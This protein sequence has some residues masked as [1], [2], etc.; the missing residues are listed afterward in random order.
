MFLCILQ[1]LIKQLFK[2]GQSCVHKNTHNLTAFVSS[3]PRPRRHTCAAVR[4]PAIGETTHI[5]TR[6]AAAAGKQGHQNTKQDSA[7]EM[8]CRF[9]DGRPTGH[10]AV[11]YSEGGGGGRRDA[12]VTQSVEGFYEPSEVR[13]FSWKAVL[14]KNKSPSNP[15]QF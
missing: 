3:A 8:R 11:I 14:K 5:W 4:C 2:F 13:S 7:Q 15:E 9:M 1:R 12:D 10:A 6:L